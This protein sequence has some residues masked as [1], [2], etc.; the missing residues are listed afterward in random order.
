MS[1]HRIWAWAL[2]LI[3]LLSGPAAASDLYPARP[4]DPSPGCEGKVTSEKHG[5][6][7]YRAGVVNWKL[8]LRGWYIWGCGNI[9]SFEDPPR[10]TGSTYQMGWS[11]R[12]VRGRSW[13]LSDKVVFRGEAV[14][15]LRQ[16]GNVVQT[17]NAWIELHCGLTGICSQVDGY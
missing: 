4:V 14:F 7:Q 3:L 6:T 9:Y 1:A 13:R 10:I 17:H 2:V 12:D 16:G 11:V 15:E 8:T 5:E